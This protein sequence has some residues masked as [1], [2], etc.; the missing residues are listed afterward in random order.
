MLQNNFLADL[1]DSKSNMARALRIL[2]ARLRN[3]PADDEET[4]QA[5]DT[6]QTGIEEI[7]FGDQERIRLASFDRWSEL[8]YLPDLLLKLSSQIINYASAVRAITSLDKNWFISLPLS[9]QA[10]QSLAGTLLNLTKQYCGDYNSFWESLVAG[11]PGTM[12]AV[13]FDI[14]SQENEELHP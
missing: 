11:N 2:S 12:S 3:S 1:D 9:D 13:S 10:K 14:I 8:Y 6:L 7:D 4:Q 5:L